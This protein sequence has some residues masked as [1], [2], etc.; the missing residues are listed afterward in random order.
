M[1]TDLIFKTTS[2]LDDKSIN[3]FITEEYLDLH[4]HTLIELVDDIIFDK[5]TSHNIHLSDES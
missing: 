5:F 4:P 2:Y 3:K 1:K